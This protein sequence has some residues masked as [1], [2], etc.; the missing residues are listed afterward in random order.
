MGRLLLHFRK[1]GQGHRRMEIVGNLVVLVKIR[2][3]QN[4]QVKAGIKKH[5]LRFLQLPAAVVHLQFRFDYI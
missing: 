4:R 2:E 5:K 1:R 3:K